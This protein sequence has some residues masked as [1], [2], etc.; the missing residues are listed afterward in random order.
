MRDAGPSDYEAVRACMD[1]VFHET[2][3]QKTSDF[4]RALWDWQYLQGEHPSLVVVADDDGRLCGYYHA[5]I[6]DMRRDGR[7]IRG[8]MV[9]DV[10]TLAS[11]RGRGIFKD[12]GGYALRRVREVGAEFVYTFPNER[13]RP[14]FERN[15]LYQRIAKVPVW[16]SPLSISGLVAG[17]LHMPWLSMAGAPFAPIHHA[18][19]TSAA[20]H[21][22]DVA[23]QREPVF[24]RD[25]EALAHSFSAAVAIS[26]TRSARYLT[27]RFT[28]KPNGGYECWSLARGGKRSAY[29]VTRRSTL[30]D[31]PCVT[32]MDFGGAA[33]AENDLRLLMAIR[34]ATE[35]NAG[36][37][38]AVT[39]GLH[40]FFG[41]LGPL[42]FV[43]VP[44]RF[45][46]RPFNLLTR[47]PGETEPPDL[48]DPARWQITLADWDV[49]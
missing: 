35:Q 22:S 9:Q 6:V 47:I 10:G 37:V 31:S 49:L 43:R 26:L 38:L 29:V 44:E 17:R 18:W 32:F 33:G 41:T 36:A 11:Y 15:H 20:K 28:E 3:G 4:G 16:I 30:F 39:M 27:W 23:V 48:L 2:A 1:E 40:P 13:S 8:A 12:M 19:R 24:T 45:N 42:G 21:A 7:A 34:L 5:L 46:P 14:S 25:I